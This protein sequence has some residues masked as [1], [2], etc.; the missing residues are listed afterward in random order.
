MTQVVAQLL[1]EVER[2]PPPERAEFRRAVVESIPWSDD[3]TE[4]DFGALAADMFRTLDDEEDERR[5]S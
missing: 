4:D 3:L 1:A 5:A 2:L